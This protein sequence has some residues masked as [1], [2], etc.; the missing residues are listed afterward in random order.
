MEVDM[1]EGK[2]QAESVRLQEAFLRHPIA[3]WCRERRRKGSTLL[4]TLLLAMI[5]GSVSV[6]YLQLTAGD[7]RI[8]DSAYLQNVLLN[9]AEAGAEEATWAL[10]NQ[11]WDTWVEYETA[12]F[13]METNGFDAGSGRQGSFIVSLSF[14]TTLEP[15]IHVESTVRTPEGREFTKQLEIELWQRSL[16]ANGMVARDAI[17]MNGNNFH[18][19]SY[20]STLA[21]YDPTNPNDQGSV[22]SAS[23]ELSVDLGNAN[24]FGTVAT[25]GELPD[26]G[27]NGK[28]YGK[29]SILE[30]DENVDWSR[31]STD[32]SADFKEI[33]APETPLIYYGVLDLGGAGKHR[34]M[35]FDGTESFWHFDSLD[36]SGQDT[37]TIHGDVTL[38]VDG[39]IAMGGQTEITLAENAKVTVY[40]GGDF[41][42]GGNGAVNNG[43]VESPGFP[44]DFVVF[45]TNQTAGGQEIS[46]QGNGQLAAA[47]YAPNAVFTMNGGGV[48]GGC[49]GAVVAHTILVNGGSSSYGFHY[50]ESLRS[51]F[52]DGSYKMI[53]WREL[54]AAEDRIDF[55]P[56]WASLQ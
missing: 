32:F 30:P 36:M 20:D 34:T 52:E 56:V 13:A 44:K 22:G 33:H 41:K 16:F 48:D 10:N 28:I 11:A 2:T 38:V 14:P 4:V 6:G 47:V 5:M 3:V 1:R 27:P 46:L 21:P 17:T 51:L 12:R 39:G 9:L 50:D 54:H 8:S 31:V 7:V 19:N 53:A 29:D 24:I 40:V 15:I 25:G 42:V 23:F 45:G 18:V 49:F 37:L 43:T 35:G 55:E 26:I